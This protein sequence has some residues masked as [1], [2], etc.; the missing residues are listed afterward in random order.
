MAES[1]TPGPVQRGIVEAKFVEDVHAFMEGKE[2]DAVM[3]PLQD[4]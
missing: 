1:S 3:K 4:R 2:G